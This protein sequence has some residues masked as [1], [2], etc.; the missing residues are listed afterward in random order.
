MSPTLPH[1]SSVPPNIREAITQARAVAQRA[2]C[3]Y[4]NFHVGCVLIDDQGRHFE[5]C[6]VENASYSVTLCAERNAAAQAIAQGSRNWKQIVIVSPTCVSPCG[7]CRQFLFE[8][9]PDMEVYLS[10]LNSDQCVGPILLKDFLP[11][12]MTLQLTELPR[13]DA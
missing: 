10:D 11:M 1:P 9:A 13:R 3:P 5:G 6:N 7:T 2:H 4:S 8:F 12:A